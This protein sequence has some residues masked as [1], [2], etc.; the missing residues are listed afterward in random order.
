MMYNGN[1]DNFYDAYIFMLVASP[2]IGTL[3][4]A[5]TVIVLAVILVIITVLTIIATTFITIII[6]TASFG[7]QSIGL[8]VNIEYLLILL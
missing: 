7:N 3:S 5:I 6:G 2:T 1:C 8:T 4:I